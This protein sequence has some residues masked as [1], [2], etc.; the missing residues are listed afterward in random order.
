MIIV[1][2][3]RGRKLSLLSRVARKTAGHRYV[4]R[5]SLAAVIRGDATHTKPSHNCGTQAR[6]GWPSRATKT[7][8]KIG[9]HVFTGQ[10]ARALIEWAAGA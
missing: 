5:K 9:C 3:Y 7:R 4:T 2:D 6:N 8:V 10:Q 1:T